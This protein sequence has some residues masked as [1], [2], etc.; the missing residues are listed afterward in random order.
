MTAVVAQK[1]DLSHLSSD[2]KIA[3]LASKVDGWFS[4]ATIGK[5]AAASAEVAKFAH[6]ADSARTESEKRI[7]TLDLRYK[8]RECDNEYTN[9]ATQLRKMLIE[10]HYAEELSILK[11]TTAGRSCQISALRDVLHVLV[12]DHMNNRTD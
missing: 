1:S 6:K 9:A 8:R 10:P 2:D 7:A 4:A 11:E 12:A 3:L 5:L